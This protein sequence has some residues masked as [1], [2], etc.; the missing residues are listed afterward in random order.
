M[1]AK[2]PDGITKVTGLPRQAEA[3]LRATKC[4][5]AAMPVE[6]VQQLVHALQIKQIELNKQNE[7]LRRTQVELEA[8][9]DRYVALYDFSPAGHLT[10]DTS[11]TIVESNLMAATLLG[12][13][14]LVSMTHQQLADELGSVR[15]IVTRLLRSFADEGLVR[16][17]RG[18]VEV[19]DA[20][21][22]RR[23]A[24]GG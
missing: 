19:L 13:G 1:M 24:E 7:E 23:V 2:E 4:D 12:R 5:V 21:G 3:L 11:G 22:L 15:E 6:D 14:R 10:L 20:P 8:A 16:L 17:S 9:R 18:A